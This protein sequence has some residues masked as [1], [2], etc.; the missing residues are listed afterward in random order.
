M[1]PLLA[2]PW[3]IMFLANGGDMLRLNMAVEIVF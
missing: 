1:L 2:L 3:M